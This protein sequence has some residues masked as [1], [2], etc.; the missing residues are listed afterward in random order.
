VQDIKAYQDRCEPAQ[1]SAPAPSQCTNEKAGFIARQ[2]KL[3]LSD[4][5]L[6]ALL[7]ARGIPRVQVIVQTEAR[8]RG[9]Y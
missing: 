6:S 3:N 1:S 5:D 7:K 9:E 8:E 4:A 2:H